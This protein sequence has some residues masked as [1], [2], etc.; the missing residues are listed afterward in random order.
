MET[1]TDV[2]DVINKVHRQTVNSD[3]FYEH[4]LDDTIDEYYVEIMTTII[5]DMTVLPVERNFA[6]LDPI[7]DPAEI[8]AAFTKMISMV[9]TLFGKQPKTVENDLLKMM[10]TYPTDEVRFAQFLRHKNLL[11]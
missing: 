5:T 2:Q 11:N 7:N 4:V 1:F 3:V 8:Q 6:G 10:K 9:A